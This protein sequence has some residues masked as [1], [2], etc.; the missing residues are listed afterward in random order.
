[1]LGAAEA[2]HRRTEHAVGLVAVGPGA[3]GLLVAEHLDEVPVPGDVPLVV[4]TVV[5]DGV[6]VPEASVERVRILQEARRVE[7]TRVDDAVVGFRL[8]GRRR[9]ERHGC[10]PSGLR[11]SA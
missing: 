8:R 3:E 4:Q 9:G 10:P 11:F 1:M 2:Q 5:V 7:L 6:V